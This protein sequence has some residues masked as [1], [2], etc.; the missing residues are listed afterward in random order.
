MLKHFLNPCRVTDKN[1]HY[2]LVGIGSYRGKYYLDHKQTKDFWDVFKFTVEKEA[3]S[4]AE[5]P[6]TTS[7]LRLDVDISV[8]YKNKEKE[9][10]LEN[11][12]YT[13]EQVYQLI[14]LCNSL[15]KEEFLDTNTKIEE[16]KFSCFLLE[17]SARIVKTNSLEPSSKRLKNNENE[18]VETQ[19]NIKR[20]FH[21]HWPLMV[22][23]KKDQKEFISR[24][25]EKVDELGIFTELQSCPI[26]LYSF[27][28]PW[29]LYGCK[30]EDEISDNEIVHHE[31]Y[32]IS[33]AFDSQANQIPIKTL[34][35]QI[36]L[37]D[38]E[39]ADHF[40]N[41]FSI[42]TKMSIFSRGRKVFKFRSIP[43]RWNYPIFKSISDFVNTNQIKCAPNL[44]QIQDL[45][46]LLNLNR[47]KEYLPWINVGRCLF[48]IT[49]GSSEGLQLWQ[50]WSQKCLE[51]YSE[52]ETIQKWSSFTETNYKEGLLKSWAKE[53]NP[54]GYDQW[55]KDSLAEMFNG[56]TSNRYGEV[57]RSISKILG[58]NYKFSENS[59]YIFNNHRW[60]EQKSIIKLKKILNEDILDQIK[61]VFSKIDENNK[62]SQKVYSSIINSLDTPSGLTNVI[63]MLT[64]PYFDET[65][66]YKKLNQN[67]F[68]IGL[69]NGVYDLDSCTFR[70]GRPDDNISLQINSKFNF[71]FNSEH[72]DIIAVEETLIKFFPDNE[73]RRYMLDIIC[74]IF[75][76]NLYTKN[77]FFLVG[78]G[79]NGKTSFSNWILEMMGSDFLIT[80]PTTLLTAPKDSAGRASPEM[81]KLRD[82]RGVIFNEPDSEEK[83]YNGL[84]K[85]LTGNDMIEPRD[86]FEKGLETKPFRPI[87]LYFFICNDPP[88]IRNPDDEAI[89]SR[90]RLIEFESKFT[91]TNVPSTFEEQVKMKKFP[92]I[93]SF[94]TTIRESKDALCWYL[95]DYWKRNKNLIKDLD[96][97]KSILEATE[98]YR[99][100][101]ENLSI[102]ITNY[103]IQ[104]EGEELDFNMFK[105]KYIKFL[106]TNITS[107]KILKDVK[108]LEDLKKFGMQIKTFLDK[109]FIL[110]YQFNSNNF[111]F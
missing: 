70:E 77:L 54:V 13:K 26:D 105:E 19:I 108:L 4:I 65:F 86:L 59:W 73:K 1:A 38:F 82:K 12:C 92:K 103:L 16:E 46:D 6:R 89:W 24:L 29:L 25:I 45:L 99:M 15:L 100:D 39:D 61:I 42:Y 22:L 5:V 8:L 62:Q 56:L 88:K 21:L 44:K 3:V 94:S 34:E 64:L 106:S 20:G 52:E 41:T 96:T 111:N 31:P 35:D 69:L 40:E 79:D 95:L 71:D 75:I 51:K 57:A 76:G 85:L 11:L 78:A 90:I 107:K 81:A 48:S 84:L 104:K 87:C 67:R 60:E 43:T 98:N 50:Q 32:K 97:P 7:P 58:D 63:E 36:Y 28:V 49:S 83:F 47:C 72:P 102:F 74:Q 27:D 18:S 68:L 17:K 30:K 10:I 2:N 9:E 53:D 66:K 55:K 110:N 37:V 33:K 109:I 80:L 93:S 101:N 91:N 23:Y 14:L